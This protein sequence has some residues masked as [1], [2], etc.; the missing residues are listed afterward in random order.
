[1]E[2]ALMKE[3]TSHEIL[4]RDPAQP[5]DK[6]AADLLQRMTLEEKV[7]QLYGAGRVVEMVGILFDEDGTLNREKMAGLF[8]HGIC[9][10]G[11]PAQRRS[12]RAA[13]KLTNAIQEYLVEET[14]LGIPALFNEEGLHGL[15]A[16]GSTSY[17]QAIALA[18]TWDV[19]LVERV[20]RAVALEARVRGSN[21]IY[22]PVLDLAREP[23]W[24]RTEETF[25]EDPYLVSRMG[26]AAV[27]GLQ[28]RGPG[29]DSQHVIAAAK[30]F[31]VHGQPEG[32]TNSAP[33]NYS[34]RIIREQ[35]LAP[36]EAVV[37]EA[38]VQALMASY[39]EIDGVPAHANEWLLQKVLRQEWG[40][41]GFVTSDG[42]G[43][44]QLMTVHSAAADPGQAAN[45]A[46]RA[47]ID[48]EIP[49]G[50]CYPALVDQVLKGEIPESLVDRAVAHI[51]RAKILLGLLDETPHV[52]PDRAEQ[53][54]NCAEHRQLALE[55]A[56]KAITLLKNQGGLLPLNLGQIRS[57]AVIGPNAATLHLGGYAEDPGRGVTVYDG[58]LQ[59]VGERARVS[60]A[61]GCRITEGYTDWRGWGYQDEVRLSDPAEDETRIADAVR[62]A[63]QADVAI[64]VIGENEA[65]C[66]EGW[67]FDHLGDRD[68]LNLL[69]RQEELV[70]AVLDTG[71]P[72]VVVLINGRPL[73]INYLAENV[74]A[75]LECWYLGQEGGTAVA[76]VLFG[77]VNPS[78]KLP[79]TFPRTVGQLPVYYYQ[80]PS[81]KRGYL[82]TTKE[83]LFPF[84][85]GLSYTTFEYSGLRVSPAEIRAGETATVQVEVKNTGGMAGEEVAQ[86]Y[87]RDQVSSITRPVKELK[88]FRRVHLEPGEMKTITFAL[89]PEKLASIGPDMQPWIEPGMFEIQVGGSSM[90][91]QVTLLEVRA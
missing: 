19:E 13:A 10:L 64:L 22:T 23:R 15:M 48:C 38:R 89:G 60:L 7:A 1:M 54:T 26:V 32:G 63:R 74:P 42:F 73:T 85:F 17:P 40:F 43:V 83:P 31:A 34:E 56:R 30:H 69:G 6:R 82:F 50:L 57:I 80:K 87:L 49:R 21:Y 79:I 62:L 77:E 8:H 76:E 51:L 91:V 90:E 12:P 86:L 66:R 5:V 84:G 68:D 71:T 46:L 20:Y 58:I 2:M 24:G 33:G 52:D 3:N 11:R 72:T 65:T 28:G 4:Y 75:I 47:G 67:W 37:K 41:A 44:P 29:I 36:F 16:V 55:A 27:L 81:A 25:G 88:D 9:Q 14:R 45:M 53:V 70:R 78:G 59:K 39:N 61:E 18:S 35:F